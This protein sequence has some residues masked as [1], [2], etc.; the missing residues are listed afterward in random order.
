MEDV[1]WLEVS[2]VVD[3]E[4]AE[5]IADVMARFAPGGVVIE[6]TAVRLDD[7]REGGEPVGPLRV[8]AYLPMDEQ[9][10][11]TRQRL[12][13]SLWYLGRIRTMPTP[14]FR[15]V[16]QTDWA[17][18]WKEHYHPIAIGER[19]MIVPAWLEPPAGER[20][21]IRIDPGMAFGTG[22][23]PTTQ[24]CLELVEALIPEFHAKTPNQ[25]LDVID[26]GCGSAILSIAALK[27]GADRALGVDVDVEALDSA[28]ENAQINGVGPE[29]Q[30]GTGSVTEICE[31]RFALRRAPLVLANILSKILIRLFDD[32][33]GKL[34]AP[35]GAL[36]LS[37]I[38]DEQVDEVL[39]AARE[40]GFELGERRQQ[41][42]WVALVVRPAAGG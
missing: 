11:E 18:A 38:L 29:L 30:L 36:V 37:G 1:Q 22:T 31:G 3:G 6:S 13:E 10:E 25:P 40:H 5:A 34:V 16:Q 23:H 15:L 8:S 21:P 28:R 32:G 20:L 42:D 26:V 12:V 19:L 17:E 24:L 9:V 4:M 33:M 27:L 41:G 35:G 39:E 7:D 2:V 14:Q